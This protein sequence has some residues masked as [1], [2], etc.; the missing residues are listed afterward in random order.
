MPWVSLHIFNFGGCV[1]PLLGARFQ[2]TLGNLDVLGSQSLALPMDCTGSQVWLTE[3]GAVGHAEFIRDV[4]WL[5]AESRSVGYAIGRAAVDAAGP[6]IG[7][8]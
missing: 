6:H 1:F 4:G 8:C 7:H 5:A 2:S 3:I